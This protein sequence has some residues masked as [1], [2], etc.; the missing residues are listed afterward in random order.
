MDVIL[1][2]KIVELL[3]ELIQEAA[4][5]ASDLIRVENLGEK[6]PKI[7]LMAIVQLLITQHTQHTIQQALRSTWCLL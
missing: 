5:S 1:A 6:S 2:A 7:G 4:V 3:H